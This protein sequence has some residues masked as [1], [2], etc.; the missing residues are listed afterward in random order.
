V[1]EGILPG[2]GVALIRA[3]K[4]LDSLGIQGEQ[5]FG[6]ELIRKAVEEPLRMIVSN[7]GLEP[8]V[9][10]DKV[11]AGSGG[12]GF[13]ARTDVYGD[14]FEMGVIDPTKVTRSALQN[15]ASVASLLLTTEAMVAEIPEKK[16]AMPPGGGGGGMGGGMGDMGF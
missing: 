4:V 7:A 3:A 13:N 8:A 1:E 5:R 6:V 9:V 14:L 10:L 15:A 12:F 2:G 16:P 11:R